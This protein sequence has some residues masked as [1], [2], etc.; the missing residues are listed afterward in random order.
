METVVSASYNYKDV[1]RPKRGTQEFWTRAQP[2]QHD[3]RVS[4]RVN[5]V[6]VN[7]YL[8]TPDVARSHMGADPC[9][10]ARQV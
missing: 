10:C 6:G 1:G 5:V 7:S 4:V 8:V 3:V 9:T 2:R